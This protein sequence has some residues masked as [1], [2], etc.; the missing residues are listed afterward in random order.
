MSIGLF[1]NKNSLFLSFFNVQYFPS[2]P[3]ANLCHLNRACTLQM[4]GIWGALDDY[5][6]K[7][8][9]SVKPHT[10]MPNFYDCYSKTLN[11]TTKIIPTHVQAALKRYS[12][13]L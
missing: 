4:E 3:I 11:D 1:F 10:T 7:L 8:V 13:H 9:A 6:E 5:E 2:P 12:L